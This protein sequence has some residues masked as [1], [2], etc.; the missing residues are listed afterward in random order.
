MN[1]A[2]KKWAPLLILSLW[3]IYLIPL[4]VYIFQDKPI[5]S[6]IFSINPE[7]MP[8]FI[9]SHCL[10]L[11]TSL[12]NCVFGIIVASFLIRRKINLYLL[13]L[14]SLLLLPTIL[15]DCSSSLVWRIFYMGKEGI[16]TNSSYSYGGYSIMNLWESG[17]FF[18]YMI[19]IGFL[20]TKNKR[21]DFLESIETNNGER[22]RLVYLPD[23]RTTI[24][25]LFI[26]SYCKSLLVDFKFFFVFRSSRGLD[27]ETFGQWVN[28][29]YRSESLISPAHG[30]SLMGKLSFY[31]YFVDILAITALG[32]LLYYLL[33]KWSKAKSITAFFRKKT[34]KA[35]ETKSCHSQLKIVIF[36]FLL[37]SFIMGPLIYSI[38]SFH[39]L[40]VSKLEN[41]WTSFLLT[42]LA[43]L[44][45]FFFVLI[46]STY[47]RI[48]W[49][50]S[51][52][53]FNLVSSLL[54]IGLFSICLIPHSGLVQSAFHWFAKIG[55]GNNIVLVLVWVIV[56]IFHTGPLLLVFC[57]I[58]YFSVDQNKLKYL[59]VIKLTPMEIFKLQFWS[60]YKILYFLIFLMGF[61]TIWNDSTVNLVMSDYI[62]SLA[63]ELKNTSLGAAANY[64]LAMTYVFVSLIMASLTIVVWN[65]FIVKTLQTDIKWR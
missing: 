43:S 56:H 41:L 27:T 7:G 48:A 1:L 32:I 37:I 16:Y 50:S 51:L 54:I 24:T 21:K 58:S 53:G 12:L 40:G 59:R 65:Y 19:W 23:N 25:I 6:E 63:V 45:L 64:D 61:I 2:F 14:S 30:D 9:K 26:F 5:L 42:L 52:N 33:N 55:Y 13:F 36:H 60:D 18:A 3:G 57:I 44:V 38:I 62:P 34:R 46:I 20:V 29:I 31:S 17:T 8:T 22:F 10:A 4:F 35:N 49:H 15:G 28:R 11:F 47:A 39:S